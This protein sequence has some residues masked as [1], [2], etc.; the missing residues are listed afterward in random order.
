MV[1][2]FLLQDIFL[3]EVINKNKFV[4]HRR[5]CLKSKFYCHFERSEKSQILIIN[6]LNNLRFFVITQNDSF[7]ATSFLFSNSYTIKYYSC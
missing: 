1:K 2:E 7:S 5:S 4:Q 3:K 6:I